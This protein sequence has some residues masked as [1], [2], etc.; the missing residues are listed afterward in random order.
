VTEAQTELMM[1]TT[2]PC[3]AIH[4]APKSESVIYHQTVQFFMQEHRHCI[5]HFWKL[6]SEKKT[7]NNDLKQ[8]QYRVKDFSITSFAYINAEGEIRYRAIALWIPP[9][10]TI[11]DTMHHKTRDDAHKATS[12]AIVAITLALETVNNQMVEGREEEP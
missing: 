4:E 6:K 1:R 2:C 9:G 5:E 12:I 3:G 10:I 11:A 8:K 7:M